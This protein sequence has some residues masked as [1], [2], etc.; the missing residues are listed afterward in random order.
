MSHDDSAPGAATTER[1]SASEQLLFG[2]ELTYDYGWGTHNGAWLKLS[3]RS[4]TVSLPRQV[5]VAVRPARRADPRA[6]TTVAVGEIAR[7]VTQA[8][9]LIAVNALLVELL[10]PGDITS[11]LRAA[12]PSLVLVAVLSVVGSACGFTSRATSG[13]PPLYRYRYRKGP[14]PRPVADPF[15]PGPVS[16]VGPHG[17]AGGRIP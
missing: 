15:L 13:S 17:P 1:T 6:L 8:V 12:L 5:A 7:G 14:R 16:G 9:S 11:R 10:A 2:G 3:L 4:M